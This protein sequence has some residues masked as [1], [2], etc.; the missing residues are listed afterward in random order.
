[1]TE[2]SKGQQWKGKDPIHARAR[3]GTGIRVLP[4]IYEG[5]MTEEEYAGV[6]KLLAKLFSS[7]LRRKRLEARD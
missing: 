7:H 5:T 2:P 3:S 1:M 6:V 4:S